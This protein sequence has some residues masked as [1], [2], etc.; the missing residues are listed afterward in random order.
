MDSI[1]FQYF[2]F[3]IVL[4]LSKRKH[5]S[6]S[7]EEFE[8]YIEDDEDVVRDLYKFFCTDVDLRSLDPTQRESCEELIGCKSFWAIQ[9]DSIIKAPQLYS[10]IINK[11]NIDKLNMNPL[12]DFIIDHKLMIIKGVDSD[13]GEYYNS[14]DAFFYYW[15]NVHDYQQITDIILSNKLVIESNLDEHMTNAIIGIV[16]HAFGA[17][18]RGQLIHDFIEYNVQNIYKIGKWKCIIDLSQWKSRSLTNRLPSL[19]HIHSVKVI[20][21]KNTMHLYAHQSVNDSNLIII[22]Y[23]IRDEKSDSLSIIVNH[24]DIRV[25]DKLIDFMNDWGNQKINDPNYE[26]SRVH[27]DDLQKLRTIVS[28]ESAISFLSNDET[29]LWYFQKINYQNREFTI[30][31]KFAATMGK[32]CFAV[33]TCQSAHNGDLKL[34]FKSRDNENSQMTIKNIT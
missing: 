19:A 6:D 14:N 11:Q 34:S 8:E 3:I 1:P 2:S 24:Y 18:S 27:S 31:C 23:Y 26:P 33:F 15:F 13:L 21:W 17:L 28:D 25:R 12:A 32:L 20:H 7:E 4:S 16:K 5:Q 30:N 22:V 29:F 10:M 9:L